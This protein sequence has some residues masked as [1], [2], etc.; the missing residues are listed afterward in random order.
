M[1]QLSLRDR[2]TLKAI[3]RQLS[4][5]V[6][7]WSFLREGRTNGELV[8]VLE[9]CSRLSDGLVRVRLETRENGLSVCLA[10]AER[11]SLRIFASG[12]FL[13][14]E[15]VGSPTGYQFAAFVQLLVQASRGR[16]PLS[17]AAAATIR[18][19]QHNVLLEVGVAPTCPHSPHVVRL[20]QNAAMSNPGRV[21][22][23]A[24]DV[25]QHTAVM[26]G[27]IDDVPSLDIAVG[28]HARVQHTGM[29]SATQL[30][31][32]IREAEREARRFD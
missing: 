7:V 11:P 14:L 9:D 26:A 21:F 6:E 8:E 18:N 24:I 23:R 15:F 5:P 22:A 4:R 13:P 32:L 3:F 19:T 31:Q 1:S 2:R 17:S 28:T 10:I 25:L 29:L 20:T 12:E 30:T 16:S 27:R